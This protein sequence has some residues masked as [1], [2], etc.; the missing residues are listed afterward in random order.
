MEDV[1]IP[2]IH[3][4]DRRDLVGVLRE[5]PTRRPTIDS[6]AGSG[7]AIGALPDPKNL[8]GRIVIIE[9]LDRHTIETLGTHLDIDPVFFAAHIYQPWRSLH[10]Q[11][12]DQSILPSQMKRQCFTNIQFHRAVLFDERP[13]AKKI[14]REMNIDRKVVVLPTTKDR[15]IGFVQSCTSVMFFQL[16]THWLSNSA[17]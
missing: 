17:L 16:H 1:D 8:Q 6:V 2:S 13:P 15:H 10:A 14:L 9:D 7:V 4:L 11:T 3:E 12:P 5:P